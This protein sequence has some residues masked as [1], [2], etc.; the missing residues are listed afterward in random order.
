M[1]DENFKNINKD[2]I[3]ETELIL[4]DMGL[5]IYTATKMMMKKIVKEKNISFL[6]INSNNREVTDKNIDINFLK[7]QQNKMIKS[8][9]MNLFKKEGIIFD[10]TITFASKNK[11]GNTYWSNPDFSVLDDEWYLIL[12]DWIKRELYLFYIPKNTLTPSSL[13]YRADKRHQI[14]LQIM[15]DDIT[16]TDI[17]SKNNFDKF[18]KKIVNY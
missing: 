3:V 4:E 16:F 7:K 17:R 10:G 14:D 11:T 2:L 18:L 5:D 12:N 15:Y 6:L 9:A 13:V 8:K 1:Y